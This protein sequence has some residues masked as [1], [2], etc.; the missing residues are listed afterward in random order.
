MH[1][2]EGYQRRP[3]SGEGETSGMLEDKATFWRNID[4]L[5]KRADE[6]WADSDFM[7]FSKVKWQVFHLRRKSL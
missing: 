4:E 1:P 6:E 5:E 2:H 3:N 7:K